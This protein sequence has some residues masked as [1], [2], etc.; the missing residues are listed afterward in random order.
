MAD[1]GDV[2][3]VGVARMVVG[4]DEPR[5]GDT[6]AHAR[7]EHWGRLAGALQ[8]YGVAVDAVELERLPHDVVLSERLR[9]R[10]PP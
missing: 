2:P 3:A 5:P 9:A 6:R 8:R 4:P 1:G 10:L 7:A